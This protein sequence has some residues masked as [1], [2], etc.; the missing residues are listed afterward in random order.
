ML[1]N[2]KANKITIPDISFLTFARYY[3][4][5][6]LRPVSCAQGNRSLCSYIDL[7]L[8]MMLNHK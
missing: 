1:I 2:N 4:F 8:V 3:F 6:K 7:R 5:A